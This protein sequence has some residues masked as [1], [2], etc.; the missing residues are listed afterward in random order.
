MEFN[1][2]NQIA[3]SLLQRSLNP[4]WKVTY[5]CG[6]LFNWCRPIPRQ[7]SLSFA[8]RCFI[9]A[10]SLLAA[11]YQ[12]ACNAALFLSSLT[13]PNSSF[14]EKISMTSTAMMQTTILIV[15]VRFLCQRN[16]MLLFFRDWAALQHQLSNSNIVG[17]LGELRK[18][19]IFIYCTYGTLYLPTTILSIMHVVGAPLNAEEDIIISYY[20]FL[21][22]NVVYG[23]LKRLVMVAQEFNTIVFFL[24]LD[25][26]PILVYYHSKKQIEAI[27]VDINMVD[28]FEENNNISKSLDFLWSRYENLRK[29]LK[30]ADKIFGPLILVSHGLA[31]FIICTSVYSVLNLIKNPETMPPEFP[32]IK[33]FISLFFM[34]QLIRIAI[35]LFLISGVEHSSKSLLSSVA[36]LSLRRCRTSDK[37]EHQIIK[38]FLGRLETSTLA[39]HPSGFYTITPSVGLTL[40][41]LVLTYTI[42]LLETNSGSSSRNSTAHFMSTNIPPTNKR[43]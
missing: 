27:A 42:I 5:Y 30:R 15:W 25:V 14:Q 11:T 4:L 8:L 26:V 41:S 6:L 2:D 16:R 35:S 39:A 9:I 10:V 19:T 31:F 13:N 36:C 18:L 21:A 40:L 3:S 37:E 12:M 20:P 7:S 29:L 24:L 23:P 22:R 17:K 38:A 33:L 43:L 34:I 32:N 28:K 1:T